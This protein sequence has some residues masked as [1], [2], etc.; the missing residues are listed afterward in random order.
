MIASLAIATQIPPSALL[1][2]TPEMLAT[3]VELVTKRAA[4]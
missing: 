1:E 4:R 3:M 2:E